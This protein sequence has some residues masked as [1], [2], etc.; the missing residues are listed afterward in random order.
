M[1]ISTDEKLFYNL[2]GY[3]IQSLPNG[4]TKDDLSDGH[5]KFG[6][7]L[8]RRAARRKTEED[9]LADE[10]ATQDWRE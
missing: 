10:L 4:H 5:R 7:I 6:V 1:S 2:L 3:F 9:K 8:R